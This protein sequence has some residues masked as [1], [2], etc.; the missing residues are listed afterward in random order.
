MLIRFNA[1]LLYITF[2]ATNSNYVHV[3]T[4]KIKV[5]YFDMFLMCNMNFIFQF[6][7]WDFG[8]CGHYWSIVQALDDR[9]WWL[10]RNWLN[11]DWQGKH[12]Y[13]E[14]TC[15]SATLS[16]TNLT[17]LDPGLNPGRRG[18]KSATN[19]LSHDAALYN[20]KHSVYSSR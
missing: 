8:Y 13:P 2:T 11:E 17:W 1:T 4:C 9:W 15:P 3:T 14:T 16:T 7:R 18:E 19:R 6:V 5:L 20:M 10:W 12:E